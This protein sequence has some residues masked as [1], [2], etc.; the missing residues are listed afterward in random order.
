MKVGQFSRHIDQMVPQSQTRF[1]RLVTRRDPFLQV[2]SLNEVYT[3]FLSIKS[4]VEI[5]SYVSLKGH[6]HLCP[7]VE[8]RPKPHV[9]QS[10]E[11]ADAL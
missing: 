3:Q 10:C 6:N 11:V 9:V 7:M 1:R 5:T 2:A 8:P 4:N